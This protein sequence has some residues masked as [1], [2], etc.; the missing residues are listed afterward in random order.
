MWTLNI[1][2]LCN[3]SKWNQIFM[4]GRSSKTTFNDSPME[5][6]YFHVV[7][8]RALWTWAPTRSSQQQTWVLRGDME[9]EEDGWCCFQAALRGRWYAPQLSYLCVSCIRQLYD[10]YKKHKYGSISSSNKKHN[11]QSK[12]AQE[13]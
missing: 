11:Y 6:K 12:V 5:A 10:N 7:P 9:K 8:F 1:C 13:L 3:M 4:S 2:L